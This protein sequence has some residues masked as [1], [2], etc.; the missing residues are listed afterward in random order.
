LSF[1]HSSRSLG[2]AKNG[3]TYTVTLQ[4]TDDANMT[5]TKT[6]AV[7]VPHDQGK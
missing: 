2:G 3:R 1:S 6:V 7:T 5:A 4:C